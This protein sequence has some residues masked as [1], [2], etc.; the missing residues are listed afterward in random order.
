MKLNM[1]RNDDKGNDMEE[2][3]NDYDRR[4]KH[5]HLRLKETL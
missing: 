2:P 3:I 1:T 5:R 4:A